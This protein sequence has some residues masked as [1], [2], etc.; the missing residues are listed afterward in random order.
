MVPDSF[1]AFFAASAGVTGALIGL[2]FV[3]ISVGADATEKER[4][5]EFDVRAGRA[6]SALTDAL[7]VS[8]FALVPG[9][10]LGST[11]VVIALVGVAS[12][13]ALG[14]M[15]LRAHGVVHRVR[16]LVL[17]GAQGLVFVY[18]A[19]IGSQL[20]SDPHDT[21][22]IQTL[23]P[24]EGCYNFVLNAQGR[25]QGDLT[26]WML[27]DSILIETA[28][29]QI[30]ALLAHFDH[31]IIMDDVQLADISD[32]RRGVLVAGP[33]APAHLKNN[34][35]EIE[36]LHLTRVRWRSA[37]VDAIHAYSPLI[38]RYELW[39]DLETITALSVTNAAI[40]AKFVTSEALEAFRILEG[41]PRYPR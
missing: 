20:A 8:L 1:T 13:I 2:L 38:P 32:Q 22:A 19:V 6:F 34:R 35:V 11:A 7:V 26:A 36:P 21:N 31:F 14:L 5:L 29:D 41:T 25:I 28:R 17:L 23:A 27:E 10:N 12:C 16:Q 33:Q 40:G 9:T 24:G 37:W 15:L 39:S 30:P 4:R 18:Q 3:A